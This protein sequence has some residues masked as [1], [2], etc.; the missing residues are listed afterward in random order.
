MDTTRYILTT[1][2]KILFVILLAII[3]LMVGLM[4]G[5]GVIGGG[6]ATDVFKPEVWQ[7]IYQFIN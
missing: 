5:Y 6:N 1:L 7:H 3:L 4:I 2:I